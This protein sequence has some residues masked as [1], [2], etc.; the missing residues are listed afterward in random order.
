LRDKKN[1]HN[2]NHNQNPQVDA[3]FVI[4]QILETGK[5]VEVYGIAAFGEQAE[6]GCHEMGQ[7]NW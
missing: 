3:D 2:H 6:I 7:T 1:N 5:L 4:P